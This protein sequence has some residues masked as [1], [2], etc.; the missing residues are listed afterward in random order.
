MPFTNS[1][2]GIFND[3]ALTSA[4]SGTLSIVNYTDFSDN[5]QDFTLYVGSPTSTTKLQALTNPGI[6]NI[7][8]TPTDISSI[9]AASTSYALG[10]LIR[11]TVNN[12]LIY[13]CTTAGI[14]D[15]VEPTW[16]TSGIGTTVIDN[17]VVWE[18]YAAHHPT[19]E[20]K[21][22]L[23]SGGLSSAVAG[24]AL[25]LGPTINGGSA[26][27]VA[28]YIRVTNTVSTVSNNA[29]NE[30]IGLYINSL[31]ELGV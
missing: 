15:S 20:I 28:V 10:K 26:N 6:D 19:T 12:N 29:S 14:S 3:S 23:S 7:T 24:A 5:P 16:P 2:F 4:F 22:A 25:S 21:L 11:P 9:W 1:S 17:T 18:L 13:R 8:L 31:I 30:E 27:A